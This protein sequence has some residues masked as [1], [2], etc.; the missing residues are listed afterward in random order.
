[1]FC[2]DDPGFAHVPIPQSTTYV[3]LLNPWTYKSVVF[4]FDPPFGA[5]KCSMVV[6]PKMPKCWDGKYMAQFTWPWPPWG[7]AF[8][9]NQLMVKEMLLGC[10]V[11]NLMAL[12]GPG[13][14]FE[15]WEKPALLQLCKL[16]GFNWSTGVRAITLNLGSSEESRHGIMCT[17]RGSIAMQKVAL[18]HI[19]WTIVGE[20]ALREPRSPPGTCELL[21]DYLC[22][23]IGETYGWLISD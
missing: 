17:N 1:M 22:P 7:N 19:W 13:K 4:S 14:P 8:L 16:E 12:L 2:A 21:E 11:G 15:Q 6:L 10:T 23:W 18:P 20:V 9:F 3:V 5:P